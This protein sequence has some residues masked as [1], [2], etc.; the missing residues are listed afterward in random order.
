MLFRKKGGQLMKEMRAVSEWRPFVLPV[1]QSKV[2]EL[3][4]LGYT[5]A[6]EDNVWDCLHK[7]VWKKDIEKRLYQV[8]QDIMHLSP[9]V[10]MTYI[11]MELYQESDLMEQIK[12]IQAAMDGL[13]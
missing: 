11:S 5:Q 1:L 12:E 10:Y 7:K 4:M 13:N 8:V 9:G 6:T 2:E 3:H